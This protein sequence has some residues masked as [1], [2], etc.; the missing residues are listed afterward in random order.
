MEK[1]ILAKVLQKHREGIIVKQV[2]AGREFTGQPFM[3][4][5]S[6]IHFA[7]SI[8]RKKSNLIQSIPANPDF[9]SIRTNIFVSSATTA[10]QLDAFYFGQSGPRGTRT[11]LTGPFSVWIGR[12]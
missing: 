9:C 11:V 7:V 5:P 4:N 3:T 8:S 1:E 2:A 6:V 10:I 12:S